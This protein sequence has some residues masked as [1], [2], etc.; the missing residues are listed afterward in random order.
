MKRI[1]T[2]GFFIWGLLLIVSLANAQTRDYGDAPNTYFTTNASNGPSHL[3]SLYNAT[4]KTASLM[5]GSRIDVEADGVPGTL[6]T[7]DDLADIDD[8]D[9]I[10]RFPLLIP[11][12]TSYSV[13]LSVTNTTG[14][15][16]TVNGW[17]DF[18]KSNTFDAGELA[19]ATVASGATS[20]TLNWTGFTAVANFGYIYA[21][22]RI[23]S[24]AAEIA[25]PT[26]PANSGEVEDHR[27]FIGRPVSGKVFNDLNRNKIIDGS[28]STASL[29]SPLYV[30]VVQLGI[31]VDSAR[32]ASDGTYALRAPAGQTST[33]ELSALQYPIGYSTSPTPINHTPPAG[34][35]TTGENASGSN[36]GPGDLS[37][38]GM[39]SV[40]IPNGTTNLLQRN[41]GITC[42]TAGTSVNSSLCA[43]ETSIF[44]MYNLLQDEDAGGTWSHVSGTGITFDEIAETIQLT[45]GATTSTYRYDISGG[46]GCAA[47]YSIAT[48]VIK[49]VPVTYRNITVCEGGTVCITNPRI[50]ARRLGPEERICYTTSGVYYDTLSTASEFG[51]DSIVVTTLTVLSAPVFA[52]TH[53]SCNGVGSVIV[54]SPVGAGVLYSKDNITFQTSPS[55]EALSAGNYTFYVKS[56]IDTVTCSYS[57]P[58]TVSNTPCV[59]FGNLPIAGSGASVIWPQA[60]ASLLSLDL[61]NT[62]R[63]WLGGNSSYPD[64]TNES[65]IDRNGGLTLSSEDIDIS[66]T[67][68]AAN[69]Y[70]FAGFNWRDALLDL[71]FNITVNGNAP[72]GDKTVYYGLWFDANGNGSFT[73]ADDIFVTGNL[74]HG[75]PVSVTVPST[76]R[77]GGSNAGAQNGAIRV[78]ATKENTTFTKAQNGAVN[79]I[80]GEVEDYYVNYPVALPV[81]IQ[82]FTAVKQ[83]NTSI[84][85]WTTTN[86]QNNKGFSLERSTDGES[87]SSIGFVNTKAANGSSSAKLNYEF[88]DVKPFAAINYY[89]LKQTDAD[90]RFEYSEVRQLN[91]SNNSSSVKLYPNPA[92]TVVNVIGVEAGSVIRIEDALGK[93]VLST[94]KTSDASAGT[95]N[96]ATLSRGIYIVIVYSKDGTTITRKLIKD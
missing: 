53:A 83:H 82:S 80:N 75:S 89:R 15:D 27:F 76:F 90:N 94:V 5:L 52:V 9:A 29:P 73:D 62:S 50:N 65:N 33:I 55:F 63:A 87:W 86:E 41:F 72:N 38:D 45:S 96:I 54:T 85:S 34:W 24:V 71:K 70:V 74:A 20:V 23:A 59:D 79:V 22:F 42:K 26:G 93:T 25:L 8:E 13:T 78:V 44:P 2:Y 17:I 4:T 49:Q 39:I 95:I 81:N 84:L 69:P 6:A 67:G 91:F 64:K 61:S 12:S 47:T 32:V 48:V 58:V 30:Y 56:S 7:G 60:T 28:E 40:S 35:G 88:K 43:S 31:V 37:P 1:L 10:T 77:N 19:T 21:R 3:P 14:A 92:S 16:A 11:G 36:S 57:V 51:C 18:N 68:T 46:S 66:G